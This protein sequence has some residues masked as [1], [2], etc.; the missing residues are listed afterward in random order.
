M[1]SRLRTF[2][3]ESEDE[4]R[5]GIPPTWYWHGN[6]PDLHAA[7]LFTAMGEP[8][9]SA[10]WTRWVARTFYSEGPRGL[11]G[12]DDGGTM[13]AWLV[14]TYLGFFPIAGEDYYL[15][16]SPLVTGAE[17]T[18]GDGTFTIE[19]PES[20]ETTL[21]VDSASIDDA[22]LTEFRFTHAQITA[23]ATLRFEMR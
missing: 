17:L 18:I 23:G 19:A 9:E 14:F 5:T 16:G 13:S 8:E 21:V 3:D 4:R 20:T 10:R 7:Y 12:N 6:E 15:I 11:P 22:A 1:L 2:F